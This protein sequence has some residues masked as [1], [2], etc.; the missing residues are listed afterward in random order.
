MNNDLQSYLNQLYSYFFRLMSTKLLGE[1]QD[2]W[3]KNWISVRLVAY[4]ES[5][6]SLTMM[7]VWKQ[8]KQTKLDWVSWNNN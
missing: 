1:G 2:Q 7:F 4:V 3:I 6:L 8:Q 5:L